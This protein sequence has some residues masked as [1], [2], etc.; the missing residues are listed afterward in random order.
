[1]SPFVATLLS[2]LSF[3]VRRASAS[4]V[5]LVL[6]MVGWFQKAY[7][8]LNAQ[9]LTLIDQASKE[10]GSPIHD[11]QCTVSTSDLVLPIRLDELIRSVLYLC[12]LWV[13][14]A[15]RKQRP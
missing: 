2:F 1:M 6:R 5:E 15:S 7:M 9:V 14:L 12:G 8:I 11:F 10:C 13:S 3:S 4:A